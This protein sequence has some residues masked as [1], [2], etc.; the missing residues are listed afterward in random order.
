MFVSLLSENQNQTTRKTYVRAFTLVELLVVIGI[1]ALLISILLPSL[2]KAR[3]SARVIKCA[4][5]LRSIG[6]GIAL[7]LSENK[8]TFPASNYYKGLRFEGNV[9]QPGS[10]DEGYV[11]WSSFLYGNKSALGTDKPF[12][13]EKG[14]DAFRC[15]SLPNGGLPPANTFKE[16]RDGFENETPN[17]IDWQAPRMAYTVNEAI[18]PRG[19]FRK[20]VGDRGNVRVYQYVKSGMVKNSSSTILATEIWGS[21]TAVQTA[22]LIDTTSPT[23]ASRR[24]V[25]GF[26][27]LAYKASEFYK[28]P[29]NGKVNSKVYKSLLSKD[30]SADTSSS[31]SPPTL[32]DWVGRNHYS[33]KKDN[34]GFD[35]RKSNFLYVDGHVETKHI[36]ETLQPFQWGERFYTLDF[37]Q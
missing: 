27:G 10:P 17:A 20:Y 31:A 25:H 5:N 24:P 4:A 37:K 3:E 35:S 6:Q 11:H 1:I 34:E 9:Q 36:K 8:Q 16:N 19:L 32:L 18:M 22:S 2:G 7:Y 30:P 33:K 21:Q 26:D 12:L 23:S 29:V 13:N 15:P 28:I 14:W